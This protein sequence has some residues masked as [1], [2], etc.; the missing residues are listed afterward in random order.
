MQLGNCESFYV[1]L[2]LKNPSFL[3]IEYSAYLYLQYFTFQTKENSYVFQG[4]K[5]IFFLFLHKRTALFFSPKMYAL[6]WG[7]VRTNQWDKCAQWIIRGLKLPKD[8]LTR[9][10][11]CIKISILLNICQRKCWI[12]ENYRTNSVILTPFSSI[13]AKFM[14]ASWVLMQSIHE[15]TKRSKNYQSN[16]KVRVF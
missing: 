7:I 4:W 14:K 15:I 3:F 8:I 12:M 9:S 6:H 13:G 16:Y 5:S 2:Y 1:I 10:E 11:L